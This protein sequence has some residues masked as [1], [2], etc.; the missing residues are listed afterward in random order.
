MRLR[1]TGRG[2]LYKEFR[3]EGCLWK[4]YMG[5]DVMIGDAFEDRPHYVHD[6]SYDRHKDYRCSALVLKATE[7]VLD[8]SNT[9]TP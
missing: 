9:L 7:P 1:E 5:S 2:K 4:W 3:L 8:G 6:G